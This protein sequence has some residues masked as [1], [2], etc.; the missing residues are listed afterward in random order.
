MRI[1][2]LLADDSFS[3]LN[4]SKVSYAAGFIWIFLYKIDKIH[5]KC[6]CKDNYFG[7]LADMHIK[8]NYRIFSLVFRN[9]KNIPTENVGMFGKKRE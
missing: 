2:T 9:I 4:G 5:L 6:F 7:T 8:L 1:A 3:L